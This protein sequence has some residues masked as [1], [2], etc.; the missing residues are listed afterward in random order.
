MRRLRGT[1][2]TVKRLAGYAFRRRRIS[3]PLG[4]LL[5]I[6][7][8][9]AG[10]N[11][12]RLRSRAATPTVVIAALAA[13]PRPTRVVAFSEGC[14]TSR[15]HSGFAVVASAKAD[16][17]IHVPVAAGRCDQCHA[18]DRGG[19]EYPLL[20]SNTQLCTNC[21]A[22][23]SAS[24][25]EHA[26]L[27]ADGCMECHDP[28]GGPDRALLRV[29]STQET[30]VRC[31]QGHSAQVRHAPGVA[32]HCETCHDP[33]GSSQPGLLRSA[34]V[35]ENCRECHEAAT[36]ATLNSVF[37]HAKVTGSCGGCHD[38]HAPS[39][40]NLLP[41]SLRETCVSCHRDVGDTMTDAT[42]THN[43]VLKGEQ[44]VRC[45]DAHG[46]DHP[47]M[48]RN[49][50]VEVC[51]S[52]HNQPVVAADGRKVPSM[53]SVVTRPV[54]H[55]AVRQGECSACHSVHGGNH[56]KLLQEAN[57]IAPHGPYDGRN[58]ALCYSCHDPKLVNDS[59]R[60]QFRDGDRNLHQAHV[61]SGERSMGCGACHV[62]HSGEQPRLMAT[63]VNFEGSSWAMPM[64]YELA[65]QGGRCA[66]ACHETIEYSRAPGGARAG[67]GR[68]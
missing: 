18:P 10:W 42:V 3:I 65:E 31:H 67:G 8:A 28:H 5:V 62:V 15:C 32:G 26:D 27:S 64:K 48:L 47:A 46:T 38:P 43:P 56:K 41:A 1:H 35:V 50:E 33:H 4:V 13:L 40:K 66:S 36:A 21:N 16:R 59:A 39:Q 55:G 52:C 53:S 12:S 19:H 2:N 34:T 22:T 6:V 11:L 29:R 60:T 17:A 63:S 20:R 45:H 49:S 54:V 51:M 37:S 57:A 30:C 7:I 24:V 61:K 14:S 44:C 23:M 58:F 25:V 9:A 68:P